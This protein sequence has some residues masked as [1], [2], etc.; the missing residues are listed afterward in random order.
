VNLLVDTASMRGQVI[1]TEILSP[2]SKIRKKCLARRN[3]AGFSLARGMFAE[4][5]ARAAVRL[6]FLF[7]GSWPNELSGPEKFY[8]VRLLK[9][10]V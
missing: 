9:A 3:P 7:V 6:L 10:R 1:Y 8:G 5:A 2:T 4:A